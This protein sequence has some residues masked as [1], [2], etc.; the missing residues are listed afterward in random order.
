M[1]PFFN[2]IIER[3]VTSRLCTLFWY[4][5]GHTTSYSKTSM[6]PTEVQEKR[7]RESDKKGTRR[8]RERKKK[9]KERK[10]RVKRGRT[11]SDWRW[12]EYRWKKCRVKDENQLMVKSTLVELLSKL[13]SE[14]FLFDRLHWVEKEGGKGEQCKDHKCTLCPSDLVKQAWKFV[15]W[16]IWIIDFA[17]FSPS[18]SLT[19]LYTHTFCIR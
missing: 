3:V 1:E 13:G 9:E 17:S 4:T 14:M 8:V 19:L 11:K 2:L 10:S 16:A 12:T 7:K 6:S 18:L 5:D 15:S